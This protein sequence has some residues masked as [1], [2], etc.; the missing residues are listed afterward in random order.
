MQKF[1][2]RTLLTTIIKSLYELFILG[3]LSLWCV[4]DKCP[5]RLDLLLL[6]F[7]HC[8]TVCDDLALGLADF[9]FLA[10]ILNDHIY[11][12]LIADSCTECLISDFLYYFLFSERHRMQH[13]LHLHRLLSTHIHSS[14]FLISKNIMGDKFTLVIVA[15]WGLNGW[16]LVGLWDQ[17]WDLGGEKDHCLGVTV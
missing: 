4:A 15:T 5:L 6:L 3:L 8:D 16:R 9:L 7:S 2:P 14:L 1:L 10:Y 11:V 12:H 17:G 13:T